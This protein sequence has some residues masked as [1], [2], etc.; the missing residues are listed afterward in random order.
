[1]FPLEVA[2]RTLWQE[3]RGEPAEGQ[4]AVVHVMLNRVKDGRWGPNLA[5]VCL[6]RNQFSGWLSNDPNFK[7][8][9][10][11]PEADPTLEK[12]RAVIAAAMTEPDSTGGALYYYASSMKDAPNW[13]KNMTYLG[14]IGHHKF[15]TDRSAGV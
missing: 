5:S 15:F 13:S 7:A 1:T 8:C 10:L 12:M 4:K 3:A 9:C 14:D 11:L 6:W 2:A